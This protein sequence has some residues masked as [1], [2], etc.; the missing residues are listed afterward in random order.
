M[1]LPL[2]ELTTVLPDPGSES[3]AVTTRRYLK[4]LYVS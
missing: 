2:K 4:T 3:P 1:A